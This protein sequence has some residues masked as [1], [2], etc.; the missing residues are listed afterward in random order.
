MPRDMDTILSKCLEKDPNRRYASA[1]AL[2]EDLERFLRG[3]P[4]HARP[5]GRIEQAA[6]WA[7]RRP[8][9]AGLIAALVVVTILGFALLLLDPFRIMLLRFLQP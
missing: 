9:V 1:E 3:E 2:A 8:T 6:K 4:I 5:A 7:K